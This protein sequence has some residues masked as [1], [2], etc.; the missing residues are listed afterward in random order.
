MCSL[1]KKTGT[2]EVYR[3]FFKML[4]TTMPAAFAEPM[5]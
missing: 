5:V 4:L 3:M 1:P 2:L